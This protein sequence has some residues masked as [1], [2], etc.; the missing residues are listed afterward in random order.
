MAAAQAQHVV[1]LVLERDLQVDAEVAGNL[2]GHRLD[3]FD[4]AGLGDDTLG[5][6]EADGEVLEVPG[7][8]HHHR[9]GRTAKGEGHRRLLRDHTGPV[10]QG[11]I[12]TGGF[13]HGLRHLEFRH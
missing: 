2:V 5:Q 6:A 12:A 7:G 10:P 1:L 11:P 3:R 8:G 13:R 9:M 4:L